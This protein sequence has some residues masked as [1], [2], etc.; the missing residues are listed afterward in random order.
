MASQSRVVEKMRSISNIIPAI[1]LASFILG[2]SGEEFGGLGIEVPSG[3]GIVTDDHPYTI[4]SVYEGGTG[5]DAG[6]KP[7]DIIE[8]VD[9]RPLKG[10]QHDHIIQN[11]L[12]GKVGTM[13]LLSVKRDDASMPFRVMR[14]KIVL[15]RE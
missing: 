14:G 1:I 2:C 10:L 7:G 12:R 6:L 4:V 9:G 3:N 5:H 15:R 11:M 13:V 8:S